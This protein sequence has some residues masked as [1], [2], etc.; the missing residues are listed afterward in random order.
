MT[1][2]A[3]VALKFD[4]G[5]WLDRPSATLFGEIGFFYIIPSSPTNP[6]TFWGTVVIAGQLTWKQLGGT[7]AAG[8]MKYFVNNSPTAGPQP[9][10]LF[11]TIAA[12]QAA[13]V[14]D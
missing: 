11:S 7:G 12:A 8:A 6:D 5:E 1:T 10:C 13:A 9:L 14:A 4:S 2:S 3:G